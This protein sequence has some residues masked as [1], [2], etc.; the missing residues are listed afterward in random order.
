MSCHVTTVRILGDGQTQYC[1]ENCGTAR[2]YFH[3]LWQPIV[4]ALTVIGAVSMSGYVSTNFWT[5]C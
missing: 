4:E 1:A 2:L 3:A 5:F